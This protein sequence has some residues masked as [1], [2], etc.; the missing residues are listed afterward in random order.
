MAQICHFVPIYNKGGVQ[1]PTMEVGMTKWILLIL[2]GLCGLYLTGIQVHK[3]YA[4]YKIEG[5]CIAKHIAQEVERR[6]IKTHK[7]TCWVQKGTVK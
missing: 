6:D 4:M 3:E 7:G 1:H 5:K 2:V